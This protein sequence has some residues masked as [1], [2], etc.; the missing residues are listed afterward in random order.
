M[1]G[2]KIKVSLGEIFLSPFQYKYDAKYGLIKD[3]VYV[4]PYNYIKLIL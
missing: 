4:I 2:I 3:H 1:Q